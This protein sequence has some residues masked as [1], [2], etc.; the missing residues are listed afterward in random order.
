MIK[1]V[2][3]DGDGRIDFLGEMNIKMK[4]NNQQILT[5]FIR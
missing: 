2:D 3:S 1:E 5:F 4:S